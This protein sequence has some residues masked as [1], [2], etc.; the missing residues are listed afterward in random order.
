MLA[1]RIE[2]ALRNGGNSHGRADGFSSVAE[3][4]P[5]PGA[6]IVTPQLESI[7]LFRGRSRYLRRAD[8]CQRAAGAS[9]VS[10]QIWKLVGEG[11]ASAQSSS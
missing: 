9:T 3:L 10:H 1:D 8:R 4:E 7:V 2:A 5:G 11:E 6:E